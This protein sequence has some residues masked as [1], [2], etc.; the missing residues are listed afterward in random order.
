M[1]LSKQLR[2]TIYKETMQATVLKCQLPGFPFNLYKPLSER[3]FVRNN[4]E[5][6]LLQGLS[7]LLYL[8]M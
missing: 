3:N 7:G 4:I 2:L 5:S 6:D 8:E 1:Q